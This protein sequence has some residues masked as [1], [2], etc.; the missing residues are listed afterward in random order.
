MS[1]DYQHGD[2][3]RRKRNGEAFL[4]RETI[5]SS[6][7]CMQWTSS[8]QNGWIDLH[9]DGLFF[10]APECFEL[11][12]RAMGINIQRIEKI[13]ELED[14]I[15]NLE[16]DVSALEYDKIVLNTNIGDLMNKIQGMEL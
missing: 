14:K 11:V 1:N 13:K 4:F 3:W 7:F 16:D 9:E 15:V 6:C 8:I 10:T 5:K 2:V 12:N